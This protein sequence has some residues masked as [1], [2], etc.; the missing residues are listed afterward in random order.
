MV[1][2]WLDIKTL[3]VVRNA[4]WTPESAD[5]GCGCEEAQKGQSPGVVRRPKCLK[6][7]KIAA[8]GTGRRYNFTVKPF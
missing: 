4:E 6:I 8:A 2:I 7:F 5:P 1:E 3:T